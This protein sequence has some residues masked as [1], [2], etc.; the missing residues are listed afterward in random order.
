[1]DTTLRY[2]GDSPI[3]VG[4]YDLMIAVDFDEKP[5]YT[6]NKLTNPSGFEVE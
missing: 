5:C 2:R 3:A 6:S 1:L 4:C